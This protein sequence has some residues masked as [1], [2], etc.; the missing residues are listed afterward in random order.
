M[1]MCRKHRLFCFIIFI[2][3]IIQCGDC[4]CLCR[5]RAG[6]AYDARWAEEI[7]LHGDRAFHHSNRCT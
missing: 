2:Y 7:E 5:R 4:V 6:R 1:V 3:F